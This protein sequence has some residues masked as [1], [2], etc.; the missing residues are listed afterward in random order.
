MQIDPRTRMG[1]VHYTVRDL[2]RMVDFYCRVLGFQLLRREGDTVS[3]GV[4]AANDATH[5]VAHGGTARREGEGHA[6]PQPEGSSP[7]TELLRLT[8]NPAAQRYPRTAGL[9]HTAFLVPSRW[10]LAHLV[11]QII[12][13]RTP[14]HGHS[15]HGTHLAIYLPDPEGN[16]IELAWDFPREVWPMENGRV[17]YDRVPRRGVDMEELLQ[18]LDRNPA[19]WPGLPPGTAVG[20]IHL[21]V[22]ELSATKHFYHEVL[23]FDVTMESEE[24]G[25]LFLSAGGYH[26]HIGGNV[27]KGVGLPPAPPDALGLR[28]FTILLPDEAAR[29]SLLAR[30]KA[31][32]V[33]MEAHPEGTLLRDPSG[34]NVLLA[35]DPAPAS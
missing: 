35:V 26:H 33:P 17:L 19:P 27:W 28:W 16:G 18:E 21:H 2:E 32:G 30:A 10:D 20:H 25:A 29:Q 5:G 3:L 12:E 14:V 22:A 13:T 1:A 8:R 7:G 11:R 9:Y 6:P 15:N 23:G 4:A 34:I 31:A 24:W